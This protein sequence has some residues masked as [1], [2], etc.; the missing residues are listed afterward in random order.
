MR[1]DILR[2]KTDTCPQR[3]LIASFY[4]AYF[5]FVF[6]HSLINSD[7]ESGNEAHEYII[8]Y[9]P[10]AME[11]EFDDCFKEE[12]IERKFTLYRKENI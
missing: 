10:E 5:P 4:D 6:L 3:I 2:E 8:R 9:D 12:D 7:M 11:P 1:I